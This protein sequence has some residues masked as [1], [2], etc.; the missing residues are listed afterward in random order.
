M[1]KKLKQIL[2]FFF[3]KKLTCQYCLT[4][5][6]KFCALHIYVD[7]A[8][9]FSVIIVTHAISTKSDLECLEYYSGAG[10]TKVG[11]SAIHRIVI[12]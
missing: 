5:K 1:F 12:F 4:K 11:Y 3:R 9:E 7:V 6:P 8:C 2:K 10:C